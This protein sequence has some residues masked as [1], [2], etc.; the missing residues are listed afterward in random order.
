MFSFSISRFVKGHRNIDG[1][2]L[3]H[4]T[5]VSRAVDDRLGKIREEKL[6]PALAQMS[7]DGCGFT[8]DF[9]QAMVDYFVVTAHWIDSNWYISTWLFC[10]IDRY[11]FTFRKLQSLIIHFGE[12]DIEEQ[13]KSAEDVNIYFQTLLSNLNID[14]WTHKF[15][16][17]TDEGSNMKEI[18]GGLFPSRP[19]NFTFYIFYINL[20]NHSACC[21]HLG[22]T[23][24]KR[25]TT[26]YRNTHLDDHII[27]VCKTTND[28]L[29][30]LREFVASAK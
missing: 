20:V 5:T 16:A 6:V 4:R 24:I 28:Q 7:K 8:A 11:K 27:N 25:I 9:S 26:P 23:I 1:S 22:Q 21:C 19:Y 2:I 15:Y 13:T 17:V 10:T 3:P 29:I 18:G 30:R 14:P 12:Y